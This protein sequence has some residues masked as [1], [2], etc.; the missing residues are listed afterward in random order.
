MP[1]KTKEFALAILDG[2]DRLARPEIQNVLVAKIWDYVKN[3]SQRIITRKPDEEIQI[4]MFE[5]YKVMKEYFDNVDMAIEIRK[6][7]ELGSPT[8]PNIGEIAKARA[9]TDMD[10][11]KAMQLI[12]EMNL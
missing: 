10:S 1:S 12:R 5:I 7:E 9:I 3:Y 11:K 2:F 4:K 8:I 6:G